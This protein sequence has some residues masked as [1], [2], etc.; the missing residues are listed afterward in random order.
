M[1]KRL[2]FIIFLC[3]LINFYLV[4]SP[5]F[6]QGKY[7]TKF[8][9]IDAPREAGGGSHFSR[10]KVPGGWLVKYECWDDSANPMVSTMT[11]LPDPNNEWKVESKFLD[12]VKKLEKENAKKQ[13][14]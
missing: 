10:L 2:S 12:R 14:K 3:C 7:T 5:T 1:L 4:S 6:G 9:L 11:F 13:K 8:Q